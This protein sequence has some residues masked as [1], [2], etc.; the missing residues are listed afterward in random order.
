MKIE[1]RDYAVF[2]AHNNL[3]VFVNRYKDREK[4]T[5]HYFL[6]RVNKGLH[7]EKNEVEKWITLGE[8]EIEERAAETIL[9]FMADK[10]SSGAWNMPLY[11]MFAD[12]F[13]TIGLV[14]AENMHGGFALKSM[15][16]RSIRR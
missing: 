15:M 14:I 5:E 3:T 2:I 13:N 11:K 10:T 12:P 4:P 16:L 7:N 8:M 1:R 6:L 9:I